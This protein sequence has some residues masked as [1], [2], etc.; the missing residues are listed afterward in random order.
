[1]IILT[2]FYC[3]GD[4]ERYSE[5]LYCFSKNLEL[6]CVSEI[7][8][9]ANRY[10]IDQITAIP[11]Y[12][13]YG[14]KVRCVECTKRP[15]YRSFFNF[16]KKNIESNENIIICN[17]DIHFDES[18]ELL[19]KVD[20]SDKF[21]MLNRYE[22]GKLYE[23]PYSQDTWVFKKG[24]TIDEADFNLGVPGCDNKIGYLALMKGKK[25]INPSLIVKSH[26]IHKDM[27]RN[28]KGKVEGPYLLSWPNN[29]LDIGCN[30]RIISSFN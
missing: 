12:Q 29:K 25:I 18:L 19:E 23:V 22:N 4:E 16:A 9:F 15:T 13:K 26:H 20:L 7:Y 5:L 28:Y 3:P 2:E 24:L 21:V 1:M 14:D 17:S 30:I 27:S 6:K 10:D 8:F 11:N